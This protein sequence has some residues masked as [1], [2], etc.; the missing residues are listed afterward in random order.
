MSLLELLTCDRSRRMRFASIPK[1]SAVPHHRPNPESTGVQSK[2]SKK[3]HSTAERRPRSALIEVLRHDLPASLVVFLIAIPLSLGIA[4][5]SDAPLVAGLVAAVVGGIV[6][7]AL[8]GSPLAVSGPAA[9]LTV[10]VAGLVQE[11]GWA[12]TTAI[13]VGAGLIQ[14]VLGVTRIGRLALSLSPAVV[15]GM[16]AGIGLTIAAQQLHVVLGGTAKSAVMDNLA[17]LPRQLVAH[18]PASVLVGVI[19]VVTLLLWSRLPKL[20]VV[21][22]PLVAVL[23]A[24][25]LAS[26]AVMDVKRVSLPDNPLSEL[27]LPVIPHGDTGGIVLA[28]ITV[29]L[30][31]SV[32]SLLSAVAVDKMHDGKPANLDRELIGQGA[33]NVISGALGGL[34]IT[35]VI[36]RSSTNVHAGAG[37][38][39]S[40]ILHGIWVAIFVLALGSVLEQIPMAAL[41]GVLLVIGLRLVHLGHIRN[42]R[43]H[44]ELLVYAVTMLGVAGLGL[45]E[46]V[47]LGIVVAAARAL[48][49]VTH[50]NIT[51]NHLDNGGY[52]VVVRGTLVFLGVGTLIK[53]LRE[54]PLSQHVQLELHIDYLDHAA[55]E[56]I[57][58]WREGYQR[59]GGTV[60]IDEVHET[61]FEHAASGR[62]RRNR[63]LPSPLPRWFAPWSAWQ[64]RSAD[65]DGGLTRGD[66]TKVPDPMLI[67]M[68]EFESRSAE[69]VRPYLAELARHGQHPHQLFITCSDSR[70]VP[71]L[72][73]SSGPGDL[74]CVRNIGNLIPRFTE[75]GRSD[76]SVGAAIEYA[77]DHL[78]VERVVV[79]G[80]S[81]CGAMQ[82]IVDR[83]VTPGT[84]LGDWLAY[85]EASVRRHGHRSEPDQL[86]ITNVAQQLDNLRSYPAIRLALSQGRLELV[87]MYFDIAA[88]RM[89]LISDEQENQPEL[90][91][92]PSQAVP[93]EAGHSPL[94]IRS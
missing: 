79:C 25:V 73:T 46:G 45:I 6:A 17:D 38:R 58:N 57:E 71:N 62:P 10:V 50:A 2:S 89:F 44:Y 34:P 81:A 36:V 53:K 8:G 19:T 59:R 68:R 4:A 90:R 27:A 67:G 61:W 54:I 21:P 66:H 20:K 75:Q 92:I 48:Y 18:H 11:Y 65:R 49:R 77:V 16:L 5:A 69:L 9:G 3:I 39:A 43:Q 22:A 56:A 40:T 74:F 32:E 72:I 33:A 37:T 63:T 93:A 70:I 87:G 55:F 15:H 13:T 30:V 88:A 52:R 84:A 78:R 42:L 47:L 86:A 91:A 94:G 26:A 29:A 7:G 82:A 85:A 51:V 41:A 64:G 76:D 35:G 1:G 31:A 60:H 14:I 28:V 12:T 23:A 80:H 24:T 83:S